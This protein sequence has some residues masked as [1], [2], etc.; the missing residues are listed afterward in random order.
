MKRIAITG[1]EST[2]KSTLSMALSQHFNCPLVDEY[3]RE[4]LS[5]LHRPYVY[6]DI[7]TIALQQMKSENILLAANPTMLISDTELI[8]IKIWM[9]HRFGIIPHWLE[10]KI[11]ERRFD[12]YL[13]CNV[14]I[15]WESDPMREHPQLRDYFFHKYKSELIR[16]GFPYIIIEGNR[17]ERFNK[18]LSGIEGIL[19]A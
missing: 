1:P 12:L 11:F 7:E 8:V 5:G 17:E 19:K 15:E 14:D 3:A 13:L 10:E 18:A 2:G 4:Y 16:Y 9:D 6:E